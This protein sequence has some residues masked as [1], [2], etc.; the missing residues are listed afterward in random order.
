MKK[1][2]NLALSALAA[3]VL[4]AG[5]ASTDTAAPGA[6]ALP[7]MTDA[8]MAAKLKGQW[9]GDWSI[10]QAGGKFVL[11]VSEVQGTAV[12]GEGHFYGTQQGD[13]KEPITKG[14]VDKGQ[15]VAT[16]PSGMEMKL[17]MRDAKT[18]TGSW[19]ISGFSGPLKAVRN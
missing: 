18:L 10:G 15:L 6:A 5:C 8:E 13:S 3:T 2:L 12:K 19:S 16:L 17:K 11:I 7:A 14:A 4:L 9:T 1:F